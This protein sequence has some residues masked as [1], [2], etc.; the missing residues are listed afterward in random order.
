MS[1]INQKSADEGTYSELV[2]KIALENLNICKNVHLILVT[3]GETYKESINESDK[4]MKDNNII[5][6][7]V[8]YYLIG[9]GVNYQVGVPY[10]RGCPNQTIR[11]SN[12]G[13][14]TVEKILL[15]ED[16]NALENIDNINTY[17]QFLE[18]VQKISKALIAKLSGKEENDD[19]LLNKL[20][21]M[22]N[23]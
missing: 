20:E 10:S 19:E 18:N 9:S 7:Y 23:R 4:I 17:E 12:I 21:K 14:R 11:V 16:L 5:F 6:G 22:K 13:E 3:D 1:W 2:A 8:S 15:Q